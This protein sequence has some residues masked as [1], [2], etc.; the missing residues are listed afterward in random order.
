MVR[1]KVNTD[2][3]VSVGLGVVGGGTK[4]FNLKNQNV[5]VTNKL[6]DDF[7]QEE[8]FVLC[9]YPFSLP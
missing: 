9:N 7:K 2:L 6:N 5:S 4:A 8:K 3:P 1:V